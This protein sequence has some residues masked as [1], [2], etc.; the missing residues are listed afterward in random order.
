MP[1]REQALAHLL[2]EITSDR[3]ARRE[4]YLNR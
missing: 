3:F 1:V 2:N 4:V